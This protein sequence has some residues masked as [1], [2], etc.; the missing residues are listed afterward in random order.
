MVQSQFQIKASTFDLDATTLILDSAGDSGN[1]II[2]LGGSGGPNSPTAN[3]AGIYMDGGGA[4]NV[5]G[6]ATNF[7]RIDG[8]SFTIKSEITWSFK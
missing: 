7:F 4:L 6:N 5:Y 2:R 1:G 3:T 8:G